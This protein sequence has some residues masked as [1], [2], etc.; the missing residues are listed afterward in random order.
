MGMCRSKGKKKSKFS[1]LRVT[2]ILE[3]SIQGS[4]FDPETE[5]VWQFCLKMDVFVLKCSY[6][7]LD[8]SSKFPYLGSLKN[9]V[10]KFAEIGKILD[11]LV[12]ISVTRVMVFGGK[13]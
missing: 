9:I 4:R 2:K 8:F 12:N 13:F 10:L 5:K 7:D 1:I 11:F 6:K 3:I